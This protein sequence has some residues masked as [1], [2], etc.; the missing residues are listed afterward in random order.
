MK[1]VNIAKS[2]TISLNK[3]TTSIAKDATEK[4]VATT[5]P[6]DATVTWVSKDTTK[7]TVG[8]DGTV[9]A[10]V[11]SGDVVIEASITVDGTTVKDSC[12]VTCTA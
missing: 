11:N 1:I 5:A 4:L 2:A 12:T 3:S 7:A 9:T 6:A 8:D 10:L